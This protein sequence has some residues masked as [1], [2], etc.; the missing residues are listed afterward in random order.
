MDLRKILGFAF[1][2][3]AGAA[4]GLITVPLVAWA[5][6]ADDVGRLNILL[7]TQSFCLLLVVL[8]LDQ[9]YV[10]EFHESKDRARLLKAC[11]APGF[12]CLLLGAALTIPF[13]RELSN[14]LYGA[15]DSIFFWLTLATVFAVFLSRFLSLILRMQERG[16]AFSM[17]QVIPKVLLLLLLGGV[18]LVDLPRSF[19][20]LL[21]VSF[22]S[23]LAVAAVYAWNTRGSWLPALAAR[24]E[25]D[26]VKSLLAFGFPLIFSGLAFWGLAAAAT[27]ALRTW[28]TLDDLA[29][30]SVAN[31]F[32]GAAVVLQSIF[33]VVWAPTVYKWSSQGVD[34]RLVDRVA[35]QILALIG[36]FLALCGVFSWVCDWLLPPHYADVKYLVP[37]MMMQPLLYTLSEVTCVGIAIQRRTIWT[38]WI[39]LAAMAANMLLCMLLVP[40]YGATGAAVANAV[41]FTVFFVAR[42]EVSARIWRPFPRAQ[43]YPAV[44]VFVGLAVAM[45]FWGGKAPILAHAI[46][47]ML[48][49]VLLYVFRDQWR[50]VL[51]F[52]KRSRL[53]TSQDAGA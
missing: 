1:G 26:E 44:L 29:I 38:V 31:S 2:P 49:V 37:C 18:V 30:Y 33:T 7:V 34:M 36:V 23:T 14:L 52:V 25:R 20:V 28:S 50:S 3:I 24:L 17:S 35:L 46:W 47:G 32:A 39:T 15:S 19:R 53:Q 5:F 11:V 4:F 51:D 48:F 6:G 21:W 8:G 12:V 43:L 40:R 10:R 22:L 41:A 42:T 27:I 13:R 16:L 9:A 45:A